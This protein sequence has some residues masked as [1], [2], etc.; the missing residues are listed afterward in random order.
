LAG[1]VSIISGYRDKDEYRIIQTD[2]VIDPG[3]SGGSIFDNAGR[4]IGIVSSKI[5]VSERGK[6]HQ[7]NL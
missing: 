4:R 2:A 3:C 1:Q 6:T 5:T 7:A